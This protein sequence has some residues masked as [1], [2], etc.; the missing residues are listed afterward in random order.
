MCKNEF[1]TI[2]KYYNYMLFVFVILKQFLT[3]Q[4][5]F[6]RSSLE[7][8]TPK[9]RTQKRK[10]HSVCESQLTTDTNLWKPLLGCSVM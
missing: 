3:Y 5:F 6:L 4:K 10:T 1:L 2:R 9:C 7:H 8:K